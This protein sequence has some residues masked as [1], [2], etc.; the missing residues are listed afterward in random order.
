MN[1]VEYDFTDPPAGRECC[2]FCN[3]W[4]VELRLIDHQ[5][6]TVDSITCRECF[7]NHEAVFTDLE[8]VLEALSHV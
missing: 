4:H 8:L 2:D 7:G 1:A 3:A 5:G 6:W